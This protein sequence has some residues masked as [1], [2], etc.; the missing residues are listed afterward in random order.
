MKFTSLSF[1]VTAIRNVMQRIHAR[2][3][4]LQMGND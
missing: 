1:V 4:T 2:T 3:R